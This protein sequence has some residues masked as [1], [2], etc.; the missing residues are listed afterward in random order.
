MRLGETQDVGLDRLQRFTQVCSFVLR[1]VLAGNVTATA[2]VQDRFPAQTE[3][4]F[5]SAQVLKNLKTALVSIFSLVKRFH[6]RIIPFLII[7]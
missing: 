4:I 1:V 3:E 5:L 2:V 6:Q 7:N